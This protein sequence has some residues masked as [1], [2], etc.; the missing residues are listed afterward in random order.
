MEVMALIEIDDVPRP[1]FISGIFHGY[2]SHNQMLKQKHP[3][4]FLEFQDI[5]ESEKSSDNLQE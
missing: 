3:K 5:L 2:V 1:P 4:V